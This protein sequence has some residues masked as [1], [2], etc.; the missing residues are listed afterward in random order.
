MK[1]SGQRISRSKTAENDLNA[2]NK[3]FIPGLNLKNK[4]NDDFVATVGGSNLEDNGGR[5][6]KYLEDDVISGVLET[7][8]YRISS[9]QTI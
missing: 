7:K 2:K 5:H 1:S 9:Q 8:K 6:N 3:S 4:N